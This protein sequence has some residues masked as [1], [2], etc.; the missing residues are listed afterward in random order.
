VVR[1]RGDQLP[2]IALRLG[3]LRALCSSDAA[4]PLKL[5]GEAWYIPASFGE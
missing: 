4:V 3:E 2:L 5:S 1:V